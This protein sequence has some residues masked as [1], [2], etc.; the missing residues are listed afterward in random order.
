MLRVNQIEQPT[1]VII[2]MHLNNLISIYGEDI[3]HDVVYFLNNSK[4]ILE[5]I[6]EYS[7]GNKAL[8]ANHGAARVINNLILSYP[9]FNFHEL[10]KDGYSNRKV[11]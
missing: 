7:E 2:S 9:D 10:I 8:G 4:E 11:G 6:V 3:I 5:F 1:A